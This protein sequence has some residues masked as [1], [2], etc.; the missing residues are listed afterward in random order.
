MIY[1][2]TEFN[3]GDDLFIKL[4]C[5]RY[6]NTQFIL[7][8]PKNYEILFK[9]ILNLKVYPNDTLF[10]RAVNKIFRLF[11]IKRNFIRFKIAKKC[12]AMVYIGGSLF[13]QGENWK[14]RYLDK[15]EMYIENKP[16]YLLGANFGPYK[17][18]EFYLIYKEMFSKFTDIS[19]RDRQSYELFNELPNVR[20]AD[21]IIFQ[22]KVQPRITDQTNNVVISVIKP[23]FRKN[24]SSY[25][26][27][28]YRKI[29]DIIVLLNLKG[30]RV[31]LM[32]FCE[33]QG[34][35]EA[36]ERI[37]ELLPFNNKKMVNHYYYKYD[38]D[39][40]INIIA[41]S[42][43]VIA[44]RFHS[45]ILGWVLN[46]PVFPIAYS[47][48]MTNVMNDIGFKGQY[49]DINNIDQLKPQDVLGAIQSKPIDVSESIKNSEKHFE[50]LDDLLK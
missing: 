50:K 41:N 2:Y 37:I 4:L 14:E 47:S 49:T 46:K 15:E 17:D 48:K 31:T 35:Q 8:A 11:N 34:D 9:E 27:V 28:Y 10:V 38:I 22:L 24:L 12:N 5:E 42:R 16:F 23:S 13:M 1:A 7:Y 19:F 43:F 32:S 30:Y 33:K 25:D 20:I 26:D 18:N 44:T 40:T 39:E 3:L 6:P 45:M 21:D 29:K 36:V